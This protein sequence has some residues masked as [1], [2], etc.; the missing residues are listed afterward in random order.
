M[1][2]TCKA[3]VTNGNGS[4]TI[5]DIE[6]HDPQA[7]EVLVKIMAAGLCHTDHDSLSWGKQLIIGHEGAGVI[8]KTGSEVTGLA[9]GDSVILNW[10]MHCGHC[11]QCTEGNQHLCEV[12]SPVA[13]GGNGYTPG[14]ADPYYIKRFASFAFV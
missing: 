7:D 8:I 1:P 14:H 2:I 3:A 6:V 12:A 5:E 10:A 4:F 13:A 11:F 9:P